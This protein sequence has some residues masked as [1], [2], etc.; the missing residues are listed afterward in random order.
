MTERPGLLT[1]FR[2]G[3]WLV[4]PDDVSL[5]SSRGVTRLEPLLMNLLV[6]LCS[7][8]GQGRIQG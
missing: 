5:V 8:A 2:L 4:K 7:N 6:F 3:E 1:G